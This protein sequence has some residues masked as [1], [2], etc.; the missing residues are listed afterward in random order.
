MDLNHFSNPPED[1]SGGNLRKVEEIPNFVKKTLHK[2]L[3][4]SN[5][6][7]LCGDHHSWETR[8]TKTRHKEKGCKLYGATELKGI[9]LLYI[10]LS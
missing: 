10:S 6:R 4:G 9:K 5:E 3:A 8:S 2:E 1:I 7:I